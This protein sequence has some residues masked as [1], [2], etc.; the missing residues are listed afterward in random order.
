MAEADLT[1]PLHEARESAD[2]FG[3]G[4]PQDQAVEAE[5]ELERTHLR[6]PP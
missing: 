4:E 2:Q 1:P 5:E 6:S 3:D